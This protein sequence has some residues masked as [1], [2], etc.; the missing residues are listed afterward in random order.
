LIL[1]LVPDPTEIMEQLEISNNILAFNFFFAGA[2]FIITTALVALIFSHKTAGPLFQIKTVAQKIHD[3]EKSSRIKLR[4]GDDFRDVAEHLNSAF[5]KMT[6]PDA[7]YFHIRDHK[8]FSN[9]PMT[10][11]RINVLLKQGYLSTENL[12][13]ET[14]DPSKAEHIGTVLKNSGMS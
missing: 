12:I 2:I 4:P 7:R 14:S 8:E 1:A 5:E 6:N 3:G 10:L 13:C 11:E 9:I